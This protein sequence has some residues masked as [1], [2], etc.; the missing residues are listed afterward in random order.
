M[1]HVPGTHKRAEIMKFISVT[2]PENKKGEK[3]ANFYKLNMFVF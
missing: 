2:T 1:N 3:K